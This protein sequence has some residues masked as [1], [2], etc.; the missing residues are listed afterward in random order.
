MVLFLLCFK[1]NLKFFA[2]IFNTLFCGVLCTLFVQHNFLSRTEVLCIHL[3]LM[4]FATYVHVKRKRSA[5]E[6]QKEFFE[7]GE[8]SSGQK[9]GDDAPKEDLD[10]DNVSLISSGACGAFVHGLEDEYLG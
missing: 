6:R 8:W 10:P 3:S 1:S 9:W 4:M 7:S 5:H 2:T